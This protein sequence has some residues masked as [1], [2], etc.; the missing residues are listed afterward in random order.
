MPETEESKGADRDRACCFAC[1]KGI[2][3]SVQ[4]PYMRY[5]SSYDADFDSSE[6]ASP[7]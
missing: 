3:Q 4:V 1:L 5:R 2:S 7:E 6:I